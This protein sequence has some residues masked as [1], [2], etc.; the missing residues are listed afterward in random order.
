MGENL[1]SVW[2]PNTQLW[3]SAP[4]K[5]GT[6]QRC[7]RTLIPSNRSINKPRK[8]TTSFLT[9]VDLLF[10]VRMIVDWNFRGPVVSG[11]EKFNRAPPIQHSVRLPR[12]LSGFPQ[13]MY[14]PRRHRNRNNQKYHAM[15]PNGYRHEDSI[16]ICHS[17]T[18][19]ISNHPVRLSIGH[20][21]LNNNNPNFSS[22]VYHKVDHCQT[23]EIVGF[24]RQGV[25]NAAPV[26]PSAR[27]DHIEPLTEEETRSLCLFWEEAWECETS[28]HMRKRMARSSPP[29]IHLG[30]VDV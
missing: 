13:S 11:P 15:M 20:E 23:R 8:S 12:S 5:N 14:H 21:M 27:E 16:R 2:H 22:R 17:W 1:C 18:F 4:L 19:H 25:G 7:P 29:Y 9:R 3:A 10:G 26:H 28:R 30:E 24:V 6:Q